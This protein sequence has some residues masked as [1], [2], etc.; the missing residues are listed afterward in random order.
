[1]SL[2]VEPPRPPLAN[3]FP[4]GDL[5]LKRLPSHIPA[6]DGLRGVAVIIVMFFHFAMTPAPDSALN[7][8][9]VRLSRFGWA[10]VD[11]F[12]VLSGFLI[13]GI[14]IDAK[15]SDRY[16]RNFYARRTVR[17]F[18]LYYGVLALFFIFVPRLHL[19]DPEEVTD[20]VKHQAWFWLYGSNFLVAFNDGWVCEQISHFWSLAVEE[21]FYLFWPTV[22]FFASRRALTWI[23]VG[24]IAGG[25]LIRLYF[26]KSGFNSYYAHLLTPSRMDSLAIGGLIAVLARSGAGITALV[27]PAKIIAVIC[28]VGILGIYAVIHDL[29]PKYAIVRTVGFTLLGLFFGGMLILSV[30][31]KPTSPGGWAL[32]SKGLRFMGKYSYGLYVFHPMLVPLVR[33][34]V[35]PTAMAGKI[36]A[37][38]ALV[39]HI[40]ACFAIS[41][42]VALLSWHLYEKHFLKLKR[43]FEYRGHSPATPAGTP[44]QLSAVA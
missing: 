10:G 21:H 37:F 2:A 22:V 41:I 14:L 1:M 15:G 36:G 11:L 44:A 29:N 8:Y 34:W 16:F 25:F 43:F 35:S 24:F 9:L 19:F 28:A 32:Q 12:F 13:T 18:P 38:P 6:L 5:P 20:A 30:T 26:V 33:Q 31:S 40:A 4:A 3:A 39:V 17:I 27:K 23:C 7:V 42:A